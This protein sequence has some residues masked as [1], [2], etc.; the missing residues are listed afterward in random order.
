MQKF[1][2][3]A[4][5]SSQLLGASTRLPLDP[6]GTQT[7]DPKIC[8]SQYLFILPKPRVYE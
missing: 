1:G 7:L 3:Y 4:R 2:I 5:K 8:I 6:A